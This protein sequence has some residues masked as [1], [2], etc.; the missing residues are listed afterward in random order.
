M[1][2]LVAVSEVQFNE[3]L[4]GIA[5]NGA[6]IKAQFVIACKY[7]AQCTT[8][9]EQD[10][11]KKAL[12]LAYQKLQTTLNGKA[13]KLESAQTWVQR[14]VKA[15]SGNDKFK[16]I[17][18]KTA[19]AK[20]LRAARQAKAPAP[21]P[22]P[23][24]AEAKQT[25]DQIRNALIAKEKGNMDLYRNVIPSGKLKDFEQAYVAFIATLSNILV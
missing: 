15:L 21:A 16:W 7:I 3:A 1:S 9:K 23:A 10:V 19:T 17:V 25:I 13:F 5:S 2:K 22:A 4:A 12:A 24:K 8:K 6:S 18:S 20:R 11:T 14:N